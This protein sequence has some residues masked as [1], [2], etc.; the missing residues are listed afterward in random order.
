MALSGVEAAG[1]ILWPCGVLL[2]TLLVRWSRGAAWSVL[3]L[4]LSLIPLAG[5]IAPAIAI[6]ATRRSI[7]TVDRGPRSFTGGAGERSA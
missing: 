6:L 7:P 5:W 1:M 3:V 2:G 4:L